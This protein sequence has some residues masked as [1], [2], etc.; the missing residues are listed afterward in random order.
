VTAIGVPSAAAPSILPPDAPGTPAGE[1]SG[2]HAPAEHDPLQPLTGGESTRASIWP[3]I[4]P[5]LLKLVR[6]HNSTIVFVNNRRSAERVALRLNELASQ[7]RAKDD[8]NDDK[9]AFGV[10]GSRK[11]DPG[12]APTEIALAHHGS[13]ARE[14]R[15][16]VEELLKAGV[17]QVSLTEDGRVEY[18]PMSLHPPEE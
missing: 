10:D 14:E 8:N 15:T 13:L 18:G 11:G 5:E 16:K 17:D 7:E 12:A 3:A 2:T 1:N 6:A 9:D 4:Y